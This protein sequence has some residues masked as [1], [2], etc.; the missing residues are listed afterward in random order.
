MIEGIIIV[1]E[2]TGWTMPVRRWS[3]GEYKKHGGSFPE[4]P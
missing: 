3:D 1:D 2:F 4:L